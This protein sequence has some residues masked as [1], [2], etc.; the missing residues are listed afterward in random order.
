MAIFLKKALADI[1]DQYIVTWLGEKLLVLDDFGVNIEE[2]KRIL[3]S[4]SYEARFR[5]LV[6]N[7]DEI[8]R[9]H[10]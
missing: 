5:L 6:L 3:K 2:I 9:A 1:E 8:G 10:V 4:E 7:S